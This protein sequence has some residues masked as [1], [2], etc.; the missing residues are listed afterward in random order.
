MRPT[1]REIRDRMLG[2]L[3]ASLGISSAVRVSLLESILTAVAGVLYLIY[4]Y[5]DNLLRNVFIQNSTGN[6]LGSWGETVGVARRSSTFFEGEITITGGQGGQLLLGSQLRS[7]AGHVYEILS[8][9][10]IP[11]S[12]E[13]TVNIRGLQDGTETNL[14]VGTTLNFSASN[15]QI[16]NVA[17]LSKVLNLAEDSESDLTYRERITD[18]FSR[19]NFQA[20][21]VVD[22]I[23]WAK[24]VPGVGQ[25]WVAINYQG[26]SNAIA[27]LCVKAG[28]VLLTAEEKE[29]VLAY[30][31]RRSPVTANVF[32]IDPILETVAMTIQAKENTATTQSEI[33]NNL[34]NLFTARATPKGTISPNYE[35]QNG[36]VL[37][38]Q[39]REAVSTALGEQDNIIS[40]TENVRP[41]AQYGL[42]K[43][44]E[45]TF[46]DL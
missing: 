19:R 24:E 30:I 7:S 28:G 31:R 13:T 2:S 33:T 8:S 38:S 6:E 42:L 20:G 23:A 9:V 3:R 4:V 17:H 37:I 22:Y 15:P 45:I 35:I 5:A 16:N 40:L 18:F 43:L 10:T 36:E 1:L 12:G 27:V 25:A 39:I 34:N 41:Q 44:G 32:V 14:A 11:P 26:I 46:G 21:A 29:E